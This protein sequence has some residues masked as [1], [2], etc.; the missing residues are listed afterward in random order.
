MAAAAE[1]ERG[2]A[3]SRARLLAAAAEVF[4]TRGYAEAS[5][6][7]I[8]VAAGVSRMTLYRQFGGKAALAAE[9]FGQVVRA[10]MPQLLAIGE[11]DWRDPATVAAWIAA[12]FAS[13]RA[14]RQMLAVFSQANVEEPG[15]TELGHRFIAELIATLAARIP[16]FRVTPETDRRR[17]L[18]AWLLLYEVLDQSNHAARARGIAADPLVAE[19]LAERFCRFVAGG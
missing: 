15:F 11:R 16:A 12:L 5:V 10:Q 9:L 2:R 3:G 14:Q 6:E 7:E 18:E 8:A 13:D 4:R 19:L 1:A 17:W